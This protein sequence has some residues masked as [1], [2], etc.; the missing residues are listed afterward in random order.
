[1]V[2]SHGVQW[3]SDW[4]KPIDSNAFLCSCYDH[5]LGGAALLDTNTPCS[6]RLY[7]RELDPSNCES[8]SEHGAALDRLHEEQARVAMLGIVGLII[9]DKL[10]GGSL[11]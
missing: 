9:G 4:C 10:A 2:Q 5:D 6:E 8:A 11:F 3:R 7:D 1:M